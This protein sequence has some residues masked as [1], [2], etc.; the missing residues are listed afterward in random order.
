MNSRFKPNRCEQVSR[1]DAKS[2]GNIHSQVPVS[3]FLKN[4]F[5]KT[6]VFVLTMVGVYGFII[7]SET[8]DSI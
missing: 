6:Q 8:E 5:K 2:N 7:V 1:I 4:S 3:R